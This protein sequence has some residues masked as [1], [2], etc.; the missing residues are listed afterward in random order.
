MTGNNVSPAGAVPQAPAVRITDST[1]R[2]GSHAVSH[3]FTEQ[4]VR[5][6]VRAL[7]AAGVP[8]IEVSHG[9]GL[10]GS[11]FAYGLS[12]VDD[13]ELIAAA[14]DE[15]AQANIAV[16]MLPGL[17]TSAD[18]A[19]AFA[20]GATVARI[21]AH[22][23]EADLSIQ[24]LRAA[25]HLGMQTAGILTLSHRASPHKLAGQARIM[26]DAGAQCVY[27]ADSAGA[28]GPAGVATR[29]R[30]VLDEIGNEAHAGFHG[31]HNP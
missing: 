12:L 2:D 26:V 31:H 19:R 30:A 13:I 20:A 11:S 28:L 18:L 7:D 29:V 4:Q 14:A 10:G 3:R 15:A 24:H 6:V 8:V 16:L 1:L 5:S 25:R 23:T 27:V 22:C 9:D 17:G 21:A